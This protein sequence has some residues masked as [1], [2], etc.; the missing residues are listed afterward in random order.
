[1]KRDC[2]KHR[3]ARRSKHERMQRAC[4]SNLIRQRFCY[5]ACDNP[6]SVILQDPNRSIL[7]AE[8]VG[9]NTSLTWKEM[10]TCP[11]TM[12]RCGHHNLSPLTAYSYVVRECPSGWHLP[13]DTTNAACSK[14]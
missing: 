8:I 5:D 11:N 12:V 3:H 7:N 9:K 4:V 2:R 6:I 14:E 10:C 1:M 13:G